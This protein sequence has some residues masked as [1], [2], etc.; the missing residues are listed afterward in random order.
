[1]HKGGLSERTRL[2]EKGN[3]N[4]KREFK[5]TCSYCVLRKK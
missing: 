4:G 2:D 5:G 1:M 3:K